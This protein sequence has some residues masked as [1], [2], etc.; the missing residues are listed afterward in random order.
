[1]IF[2]FLNRGRSSEAEARKRRSSKILSKYKIPVNQYLPVIDTEVD[3]KRRSSDEVAIRAMCL[4]MVSCYAEGLESDRL[5]EISDLYELNEF[6][7]PDECNFLSDS[8]PSE[9]IRTQFIWR[10]ESY[11]VLLWALGFVEQL[12]T[13]T[14][15]CDVPLSVMTMKKESRDSYLSKASLRSQ[16]EIL[17]EADLIYRYH[18]AVRDAQIKQQK[19]PGNLIPDVVMER[20]YALNWLVGY[21]DLHWDDITTDT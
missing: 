5:Q 10:Y 18:W 1:M 11:W 7:T 16:T 15:V 8:D 14:E 12:G 2:N 6:Y 4:C 17:N 21:C 19:S 13:P 9:H 20:H 3:S